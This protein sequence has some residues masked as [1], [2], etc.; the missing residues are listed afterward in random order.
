MTD[1][2]G[3]DWRRSARCANGSCVAVAV[4]EQFVGMRDTKSWN[5]PVLEFDQE[6]WRAFVAGVRNG[7]FDLATFDRP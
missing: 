4:T 5:G 2:S 3:A 7:E 1:W 6:S